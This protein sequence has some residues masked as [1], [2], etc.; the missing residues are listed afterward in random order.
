MSWCT[1]LIWVVVNVHRTN[2]MVG[3]A[4]IGGIGGSWDSETMERRGGG[5]TRRDWVV[6]W[7]EGYWGAWIF[8]GWEDCEMEGSWGGGIMGWR[9]CMGWWDGKLM[10]CWDGWWGWRYHGMVGWCRGW[11][12]IGPVLFTATFWWSSRAEGVPARVACGLPLF[13]IKWLTRS[14]ARNKFSY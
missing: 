1:Y 6:G 2:G 8:V 14:C 11:T 3:C 7:R 4:W 9:E 13:S 5:M 10:E 12:F